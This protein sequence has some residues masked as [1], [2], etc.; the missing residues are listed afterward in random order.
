MIEKLTNIFFPHIRRGMSAECISCLLNYNTLSSARFRKNWVSPS[1][2]GIHYN[3][4]GMSAFWN[5]N[6]VILANPPFSEYAVTLPARTLFWNLNIVI[7]RDTTYRKI[8]IAR[9]EGGGTTY[10]VASANP[11]YALFLFP[12][13]NYIYVKPK[14]KQKSSTCGTGMHRGW[15]RVP[16][17]GRHCRTNRGKKGDKSSFYFKRPIHSRLRI[18]ES[19]LPLF[20][21]SVSWSPA[22]SFCLFRSETR[23]V[24]HAPCRSQQKGKI[25]YRPI[26]LP[27]LQT[28]SLQRHLSTFGVYSRPETREQT[29]TSCVYRQPL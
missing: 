26:H 4:N 3:W 7:F 6:V 29:E 22:P 15:K 12:H 16:I 1:D 21:L 2:Y 8:F 14:R 23:S 25:S 5:L 20:P 19:S 9:T 28:R 13:F 24:A 18:R 27:R 17:R 10:V 11:L